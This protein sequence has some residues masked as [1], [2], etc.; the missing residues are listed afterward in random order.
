[1][2]GIQP[3][4]AELVRRALGARTDQERTAAFEAIAGKYRLIV[5]RQCASWF[6]D[7]D[8]A[9]DVGQAA[10]EAAFTLLAQGKGPEWPDKLAGWLI[11][12]ARHR[13]QEYIRKAK[14]RG[15]QWADLPEGRSLEETEDDEDDRSG[16]A[17]RRAHATKL[18]ERVVATFTDRQQEIYQLRFVQELTGRE[19]AG[20]LGIADKAA[21]NEATIVQGLIA[22]GFGALILMQEG[23]RY[24]A[25]LARI[26]DDAAKTR[27]AAVTPTFAT[28]P[29]GEDIFTASLRQRIANHFNFCDVCD[30]CQT[31]NTKRRQLVGP[32][33]PALIPILFAGEFRDR[34]DEVI[35]RV[36]EQAHVGHNPPR[37]PHSSASATATGGLPAMAGGLLATAGAGTGADAAGAFVSRLQSL[38]HKASESNRVPRWL[39]RAIPHDAGPGASI[40]VVAAFVVAVIVAVV[41]IA[42]V[43]SALTSGGSPTAQ[44]G[45]GSSGLGVAGTGGS[46]GSAPPTRN[47]TIIGSTYV[48]Q[49][50]SSVIESH[51]IDVNLVKIIDPAQETNVGDVV[52]GNG[53]RLVALIF[54][55]KCISGGEYADANVAITTSD[56]QYYDPVTAGIVG[57]AGIGDQQA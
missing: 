45:Q 39:R 31:C 4:D 3:S 40:A 20:R 1:M 2:E 37:Q 51:V 54:Q 7:P 11:E 55:M 41:V 6:P 57:Y 14:P 38:V 33:T 9:Q 17:S 48:D 10:F 13:G 26:L 50:P 24:C 18:V 34:I 16:S 15:V 27:P 29:A 56:G 21:S 25:N 8:A 28:A 44:A 36:V 12:I 30:N 47:P 32:Y 46:P 22:D 5:L 43:A 52:A 35:R 19:I 53:Y 23:R 42:S 49:L